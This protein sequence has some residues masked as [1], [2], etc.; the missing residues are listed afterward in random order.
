M[1][2][3]GLYTAHGAKK[4]TLGGVVGV[5]QRDA[6]GSLPL[7]QAEFVLWGKRG[8]GR[9]QTGDQQWV[10]FGEHRQT[11]GGKAVRGVA[12]GV[13]LLGIGGALD[14]FLTEHVTS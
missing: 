9:R 11:E 5:N 3:V 13:H 8:Q 4:K 12:Q 7:R 2:F 6:Q 14:A 10:S 1:S